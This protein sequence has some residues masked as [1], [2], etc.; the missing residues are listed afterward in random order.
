MDSGPEQIP[1]ASPELPKPETV[2]TPEGPSR[3][4]EAAAEKTPELAAGTIN[5][6]VQTVAAPAPLSLP[7][8]V[9]P[10][11]QTT[12]DAD[13]TGTPLVADDVEVIEKPW[14]DKAKRIIA[15]TKDDPYR[16][17]QAVGGMKRSYV[18]KRYNKDLKEAA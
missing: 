13:D 2:V 10:Q 6:S 3:Q 15:E 17:E 1:I 12:T 16:Q 5:R 4:P 18:K 8:V 7:P 11:S 9:S 14:V